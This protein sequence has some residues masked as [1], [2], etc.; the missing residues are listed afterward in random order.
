MLS[1]GNQTAVVCLFFPNASFTT[2]KEVLE[3]YPC[4][5]SIHTLCVENEEKMVFGHPQQ[6]SIKM[7][8]RSAEQLRAKCAHDCVF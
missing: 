3:L 5:K 4:N 7:L 6:P 1:M 2:D 8:Q